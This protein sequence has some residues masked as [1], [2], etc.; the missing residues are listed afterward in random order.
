MP[1]PP[2][3]LTQRIRERAYDLWQRDGCPAGQ[4]DRH[5]QRASDDEHATAELLVDIEEEDSF[6]ASDPPSRSV[7]TGLR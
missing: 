4:A 7:V 5:W 6:P 1:K 2:P 3:D